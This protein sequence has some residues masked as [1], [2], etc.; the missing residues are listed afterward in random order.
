MNIGPFVWLIFALSIPAFVFGL[1]KLKAFPVKHKFL[2]AI[3]SFLFLYGYIV[4]SAQI[5]DYRLDK[6][7]QQYDLN[8]DGMFN[9]E[10]LTPEAENVMQRVAQDTGR[11]L[12]PIT[13]FIISWFYTSLFFGI[14]ILA[15]FRSRSIRKVVR[16]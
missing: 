10:E 11:T 9:S 5:E 1:S 14:V 7:L 15:E 3:I 12:A 13:G 4:A 16:S 2:L 8:G 6:E